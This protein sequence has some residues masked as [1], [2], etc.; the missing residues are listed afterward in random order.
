MVDPTA[1]V[2][3]PAQAMAAARA[4]SGDSLRV[5]RVVLAPFGPHMV[6]ALD[7]D[8][9]QLRIDATSGEPAGRLTGEEAE[10]MIRTRFGLGGVVLDRSLEERSSWRYWGDAGLPAWVFSQPERRSVVYAVGVE[11]GTIRVRT[12]GMRVREL[13]GRSHTLWPIGVVTGSEGFRQ[14]TMLIASILSLLLVATGLFL[15]LPL[16]R[17]KSAAR[18][19][20]AT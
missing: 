2:I 14:I 16:P 6:Y 13:F 3:S 15:V 10:A 12:N 4:R 1:V 7:T 8:R 11:A 17:R 20:P 19:E 18:D 9:G 5:L